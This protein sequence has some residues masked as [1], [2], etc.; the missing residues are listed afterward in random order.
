MR[1][2]VLGATGNIGTSVLGAL[3]AEPSVE[4][5]LGVARRLPQATFP[6]TTFAAADVTR[7]DVAPLLAG[8]DAVVLL[9]WLMQPSRDRAALWRTNVEGGARVLDAVAA[10]GV[11]VLV[12]ASSIG[13]YSPAPAG[14]RVNESWPREGV[15]G[16]WYS[17]QKAEVERRVDAWE[18]GRPDVRVVRLRYAY[19]LKRPSASQQRRLFFG[20]FLPTPLLRPVL[21]P[22]VPDVPGLEVQFVHSDDV[23]DAYR[24]ALVRE[25]RGAFNLAAEPPLRPAD[26]ARLLR[27]RTLPVPR[28]L[29]RAFVAATWRARL[30]PTS[31]D[32]VDLALASPLLDTTRARTELGWEP[33]TDAPRALLEWLEALREGAGFPTPPLRPGRSLAELRTRVGT[34]E[35]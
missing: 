31:P 20:P 4:S 16:S 10:A 24:L 35:R 34:T 21:L 28:A 23:G 3:G 1:V 9:A 25:V 27:S 11:R 29:L 14:A 2:V 26:V 8:A 30:Q 32:W 18:R 19:A 17:E 7:D 15:R 33:R 12:V 13:V 5:V 22:F 6:K